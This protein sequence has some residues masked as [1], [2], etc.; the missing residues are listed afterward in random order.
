VTSVAVA[1]DGKTFITSSADRTV[2]VWDAATFKILVRLRGHVGEVWSAAISPDARTVVSGGADGM[3]KLWSTDT[4]HTDTIVENAGMVIG[5]FDGGRRLLAGW[6]NSVCVWTP[7][8]KARADFVSP[9]NLA[10]IQGVSKK[11]S[12][13]KPDEPLY[14]LGRSDGMVEFW[15]LTTGTRAT[16]WPA[17]DDGIGAVAFSADGKR[18]ATGSSKGEVKIWD[19][20]TRREVMRT[21]AVDRHLL[22]LAFSADG[23][24]LA[25]AGASSRVWV[26]DVATG[27][28]LLSL[29]GHG[30][31]VPSV[32]F[33]PDGRLLATTTFT[34]GEARLWELPSGQL[35]A[36][37]KGHV[38]GVIAVDFSPDGKTLVTA[39]HDR[40]VKLW[41]V[42]TRQQLVTIPF[43]AY[44][45]S[46]RFS[47]DGRA[48]AIG[49]YDLRGP[50]VQLMRTPSF[51]EIAAQ[52]ANA[53]AAADRL[54][55]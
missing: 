23:K 53:S 19:S 2:N 55:P 27:R 45:T 37:L 44:V 25:G 21:E 41:N 33:S 50:Q 11:V 46:A 24:M 43:A 20:A 17:H 42:A 15:H 10:I 4:R 22:C 31:A 5:F 54:N 12:D 36:T 8:S 47:P 40:K 39:S 34:A 3:T 49:Y 52:E 1:E 35:L 38:Q 6:T 28:Q 29:G 48:L 13:A 26:W 7:E 32:A 16:A 51:E 30:Q 9:T 18:L 14:A